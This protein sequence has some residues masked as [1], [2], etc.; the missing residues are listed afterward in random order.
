MLGFGLH[1]Y[2]AFRAIPALAFIPFA[3]L[4]KNN[5]K[6]FIAVYIFASF[7]AFLPLGIYFLENPQDF[8]GRTSQVSVFSSEHTLKDLSFNIIKTVGMFFVIGDFNWRHNLAGSPSLWWPIAIFFLAGIWWSIKNVRGKYKNENEALAPKQVP[9]FLALWI[10]LMLLPVVTSNEGLPHALRSI[11]LIPPIYILAA[12][13]LERMILATKEWLAKMS[14]EYP[15]S[16]NQLKRIKIALQI[17]LAAT[18][19]V[20]FLNTFSKYFNNW[21]TNVNTYNAFNGRYAEIGRHL[22]KMPNDI[23]KYVIVNS[24]GVLAKGIP[25]PA[26]T[27]MFFTD[28]YT[29]ERQAEKNIKYILPEDAENIRCAEKCVAVTLETDWKIREKIK[30]GNPGMK[31]SSEAGFAM[32]KNY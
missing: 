3:T 31:L 19:V 10:F 1:T 2:I 24:D 27:V 16:A 9:F 8:M 26:Q 28:T 7:L 6:K 12:I 22:D 20:Y 30:N 11:L 13:G 17:L 15:G 21:A 5:G 29:G 23:E 18:F 25:M 32:L 4:W 14:A